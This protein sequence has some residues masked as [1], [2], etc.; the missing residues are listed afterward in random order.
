M[1]WRMSR[2]RL[3]VEKIAIVVSMDAITVEIQSLAGKTVAKRT[4]TRDQMNI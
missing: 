4:M 1:T 2:K 3:H